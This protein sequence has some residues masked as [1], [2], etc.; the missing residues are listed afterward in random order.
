MSNSKKLTEKESRIA[1]IR[2]WSGSTRRNREIIGQRI[3]ISR[4]EMN[5]FEVI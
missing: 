3:K 4:C 1:T 2:S 5:M